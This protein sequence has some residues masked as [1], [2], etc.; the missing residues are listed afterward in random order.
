M[1]EDQISSSSY[2]FDFV[3]LDDELTL[4]SGRETNESGGEDSDAIRGV[5][6]RKIRMIESDSEVESDVESE[7]VEGAGSS[8]WVLCGDYDEVPPNVQFIPGQNP[9]ALRI[10]SDVKQPI[11]FL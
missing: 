11:D 3:A 2:K 4:I 8:T 6:R 9:T 1:E 5:R 10:V 7:A